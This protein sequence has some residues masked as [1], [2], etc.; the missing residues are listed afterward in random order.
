MK[1]TIFFINKAVKVPNHK[2]LHYWRPTSYIARYID[3]ILHR[4]RSARLI[5]PEADD[6]QMLPHNMWCIYF[7]SLCVRNS[8]LH[9]SVMT[10][11][12]GNKFMKK[13]SAIKW[14]A[15]TRVYHL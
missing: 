15:S 7:P 8:L 9:V 4:V 2:L 6:N 10:I 11:S 3:R 5:I 14:T 1:R 13:I 12:D